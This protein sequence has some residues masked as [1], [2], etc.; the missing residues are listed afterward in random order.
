MIT[1]L[2]NPARFM[3]VSRWLAPALGALA[4]AAVAS[5]SAPVPAQL[6]PDRFR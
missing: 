5:A 2:A 4:A 1:L 3:A 6:A